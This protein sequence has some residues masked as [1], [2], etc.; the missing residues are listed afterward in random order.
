MAAAF[1]ATSA[2]A[3]CCFHDLNR[4]R[5]SVIAQWTISWKPSCFQSAAEAHQSPEAGAST[6]PMHVPV[7]LDFCALVPKEPECPLPLA[8]GVYQECEDPICFMGNIFRHHVGQLHCEPYVV[9]D[10]QGVSRGTRQ[11]ATQCH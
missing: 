9:F 7:G 8:L 5:G 1:L 2:L 4:S 6:C 10:S 11:A 3:T